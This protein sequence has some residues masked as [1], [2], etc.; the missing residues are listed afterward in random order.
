MCVV[1][2]EKRKAEAKKRQQ[3][4]KLQELEIKDQRMIEKAD[5]MIANATFSAGSAGSLPAV[6]SFP[7]GSGSLMSA[8][9]HISHG[10]LLPASS[11]SS[12]Q[13]SNL[14][15]EEWFANR[16]SIQEERDHVA[17]YGSIDVTDDFS[18]DEEDITPETQED[19][20]FIDDS[21]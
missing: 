1:A 13:P 10:H 19:R 9:S 6:T 21:N 12:R 8:S 11:S 14:R 16:R 2:R 20:D 17:R 4:L 15:R 3:L 7:A 18:G 5:S